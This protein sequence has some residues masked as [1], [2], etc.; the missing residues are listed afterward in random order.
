MGAKSTRGYFAVQYEICSR[1]RPGN[2][3]VLASSA[4]EF[5]DAREG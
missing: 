4:S 2:A 1:L 3:A 5:V